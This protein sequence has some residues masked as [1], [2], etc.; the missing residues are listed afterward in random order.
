MTSIEKENDVLDFVS[1]AKAAFEKNEKLATFTIGE[2]ENGCLFAVKWGSGDDCI[3]V[4]QLN[5]GFEPR[6]YQHVMDG[7]IEKKT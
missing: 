3:L 2:I 7:F 4:F 5:S 6:I 1:L